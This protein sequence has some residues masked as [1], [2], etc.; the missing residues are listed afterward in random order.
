MAVRVVIT[1]KDG[2]DTSRFAGTVDRG[3]AFSLAQGFMAHFTKTASPATGGAVNLSQSARGSP[4]G[5]GP[6]TGATAK[7]TPPGS[8]PGTRADPRIEEFGDSEG[9]ATR[10]HRTQTTEIA[11]ER[12]GLPNGLPPGAE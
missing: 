10:V 7:G 2:D 3:Y 4:P 5:E 9:A 11:R 1:I 12:L 6:A 8:T